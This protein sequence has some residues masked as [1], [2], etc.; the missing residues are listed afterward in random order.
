MHKFPTCPGGILEV[1]WWGVLDVLCILLG[2]FMEVPQRLPICSAD[3]LCLCMFDIFKWSSMQI[4]MLCLFVLY[5]QL[6][7][8]FMNFVDQTRMLY[9]RVFSSC[10]RCFMRRLYLTYVTH[11][12]TWFSNS[13]NQ[14]YVEQSHLCVH[15]ILHV[16]STN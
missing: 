12:W 10:L 7:V 8:Y 13:I 14:F 4:I 3:L 11:V 16:P 15:Y 5:L 6:C 9:K 2:G 1:W